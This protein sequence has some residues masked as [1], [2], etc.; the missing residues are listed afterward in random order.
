MQVCE[1]WPTLG[2]GLLL[3]SACRLPQP[4]GASAKAE[5]EPQQTKPVPADRVFALAR[6]AVFHQG[7][8]AALLNDLSYGTQILRL[9][10]KRHG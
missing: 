2:L 7:P 1:V 4:D 8:A 9:R 10:R 6:G 5:S 3:G